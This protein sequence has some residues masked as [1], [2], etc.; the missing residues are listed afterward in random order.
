[1]CKLTSLGP[2]RKIQELLGSCSCHAFHLCSQ[3]VEKVPSRCRGSRCEVLS[4]WEWNLPEC[5]EHWEQGNTERWCKSRKAKRK[6]AEQTHALEHGAEAALVQTGIPPPSVARSSELVAGADS[7]ESE[8]KVVK[9]K[10]RHRREKRRCFTKVGTTGSQGGKPRAVVSAAP[11]TVPSSGN[12]VLCSRA[13]RGLKL[14]SGEE[15]G[16]C[17]G[18]EAL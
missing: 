13:E 8:A 4:C 17:W 2:I 16:E 18:P 7:E 6:R 12:G 1:M 3:W 5:S 10:W 11:G 15:T 14:L 9:T